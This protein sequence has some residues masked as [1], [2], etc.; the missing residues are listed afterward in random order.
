MTP[1]GILSLVTHAATATAACVVALR[2][3]AVAV[4]AAAVAVQLL[5]A[6][7]RLL[8]A[9]ILDTAPL[10]YAGAALVAFQLDVVAFCMWP[11]LA[12]AAVAYLIA[13]RR[14]WPVLLACGVLGAGLA[15]CYPALHGEPM[16]AFQG[17]SRWVALAWGLDA[18][19]T[20]RVTGPWSLARLLR[21]HP[22]AAASVAVLGEQLAQLLGTW[23][24]YGVSGRWHVAQFVSIAGDALLLGMLVWVWRAGRALR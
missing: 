19:V 4:L 7:F 10:P 2:V 9:P 14:P 18:L 17:A 3:R 24:G 8:L 12:A 5:L 23:T 16:V 15:A 20:A 6:G 11:A 13:R 21:R 1:L 22:E